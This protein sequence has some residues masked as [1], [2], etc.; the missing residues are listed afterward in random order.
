M[1]TE[2]FIWGAFSQ[3]VLA[4]DAL[5]NPQSQPGQPRRPAV[6]HR[7]LKP[8][9]IFLLNDKTIKLGDFGLS[10]LLEN[11]VSSFAQTYVGTP[12][13]MSP[14]TSQASAL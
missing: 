14:V 2:Q 10:R 13:Y 12:L 4:L 6:I 5:H 9:N 1:F 11:P 7:D 8:G 3:I